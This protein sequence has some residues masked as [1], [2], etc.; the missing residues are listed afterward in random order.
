V[1]EADT[2]PVASNDTANPA[3]FKIT[4]GRLRFFTIRLLSVTP[5]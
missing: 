5:F 2:S 1:I 4:N 3:K